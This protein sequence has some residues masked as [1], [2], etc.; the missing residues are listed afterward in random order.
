MRRLVRW[1]RNAE[2]WWRGLGGRRAGAGPGPGLPGGRPGHGT[3]W[4]VSPRI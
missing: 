1:R 3:E 4:T 2:R